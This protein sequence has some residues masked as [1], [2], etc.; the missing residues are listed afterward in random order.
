MDDTAERLDRLEATIGRS[1][2]LSPLTG[3]LPQVPVRDTLPTATVDFAYRL[4]VISGSPSIA[5][6]CLQ[7]GSDAW[8]WVE[9]ATGTP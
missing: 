4:I 3:G 6:I 7:D 9:V 1:R 2:W 5:Y 8:E